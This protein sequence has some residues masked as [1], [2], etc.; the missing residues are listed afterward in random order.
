MS[1][2]IDPKVSIIIP[3]YNGKNFLKQAID[4]AVGQTYKNI[5]ILVVNDGS[6]DGGATE[7]IALSYGDKVKYIC[8]EN[9]GVSSALNMGIREMTGEYF[10]WLS[11]DDLYSV[12]KVADAID[13]LYS[14]RMLGTACVAYT[15]GYFISAGGGRISPFK[16][17]FESDKMYSGV[18]V[19]NV[20]T[21][22]GTLNGCCMLIPKKV[23]EKVG[24][25]NEDLRYS[26]DSLMWYQMFLAGCCLVSDNKPNVM[27]RWH[28]AQVTKTRRD[29]YEKDALYIAEMLV[30]PLMALDSNHRLFYQYLKR[31]TKSGCHNMVHYLIGHAKENN[32]FSRSQMCKI[33]FFAT[34]GG[35]RYSCVKFV[36]A[37]TLA[38]F[39]KVKR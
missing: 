10:S 25:F 2:L 28:D 38:L 32:I 22:K 12:T 13:L 23:F 1:N 9:G 37:L 16:T 5:E 11:H 18:E 21:Q 3:V 27:N 19:I 30:D 6:N 35:A 33:R 34:V 15:G 20:M 8:K 39:R 36:K 14:K 26:Q 7:K 4:T 31:S 17:F 24:V 29:L